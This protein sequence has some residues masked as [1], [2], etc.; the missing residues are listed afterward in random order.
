[1]NREQIE[2]LFEEAEY[3]KGKNSILIGLNIISKYID[4]DLCAEHDEIYSENIDKLIEKGMTDADWVELSK[5]DWRID[6]ENDC[7]AHFA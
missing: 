7:L 3:Y 6:S 2:K 4:I 1:M 5:T